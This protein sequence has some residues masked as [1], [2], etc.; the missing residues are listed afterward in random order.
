VRRTAIKNNFGFQHPIIQG[1]MKQIITAG[2]V[3]AVSNV[4]TPGI[5]GCII[6][7]PVKL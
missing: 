2:L 5:I 4:G 7:Q 3:S 1:Q 6:F